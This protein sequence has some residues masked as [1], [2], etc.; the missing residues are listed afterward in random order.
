MAGT[1]P[2]VFVCQIAAAPVVAAVLAAAWLF[3]R[4][5]EP[6]STTTTSSPIVG[7]VSLIA[8][9]FVAC[10]FGVMSFIGFYQGWRIGWAYGSGGHLRS[11][12]E[13]AAPVRWFRELGKLR[14]RA[15]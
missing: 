6:G 1:Y 3:W 9:L 15:Y 14:A 7:A 11:I 5:V 13:A 2:G 8:A 12:V 4:I 10:F